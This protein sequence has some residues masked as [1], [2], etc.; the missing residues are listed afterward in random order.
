MEF[1]VVECLQPEACALVLEENN[2]CIPHLMQV[3]KELWS[4]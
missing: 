4:G 1:Y 2:K 3:P